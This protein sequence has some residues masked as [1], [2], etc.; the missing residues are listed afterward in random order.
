[1][2]RQGQPA[3]LISTYVSNNLVPQALRSNFLANPNTGVANFTTNGGKYRYNSLQTEIR[4]RF[5]AGFS[6]QANYTFQK[7]LAD[8][9]DDGQ[10]R[11]NPYLDNQNRRLDFGRPDFDRTHTFNFNGV[12]ELPF[13]KGKRFLNQGGIVD[14]IFGGFQLSS[15]VTLSSG[16][17]LGVLDPRGTLNRTARSGRQSA[18]SNLT[19]DQIKELTGVFKTPNGVYA[20]NPSVLFATAQQ[21]NNGVAVAGTSTR[22]DLT[23][24]LQPGF[25]ITSVRG[26]SAIDQ[27]PFAEQIFFYARPGET[28]NLPR[29]FINGPRYVNWDAGISKNIRF[30]ETMRLQL[31]GEAFNVLNNV[32]FLAGDFNINSVS[33]GQITTDYAPRVIQF[34][35]R[36]DF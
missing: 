25:R 22:V 28:G 5:S 11:V 3:E 35:A 14:K 6:L 23:Q 17:P 4:R 7:T 31:R 19:D 18:N 24:P 2:I 16:V 32:N 9:I 26:A 20:I 34:G 12:A 10:T 36:F 30:T 8:I 33:F 1:M 21:F 13:G 29:N 27:A 15:I